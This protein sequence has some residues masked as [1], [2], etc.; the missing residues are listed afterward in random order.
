MRKGLSTRRLWNASMVRSIEIKKAS[1]RDRL[2]VDVDVFMNEPDDFDFSPRAS[3]EGNSLSITNAGADAGGS[4]DLDEDQMNAAERDRM[5]ELR[6]KFSVDGMHGVLTHKT[7]NV[8]DGPNAKKL[9]EP[10]WKTVLPL[11]L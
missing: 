2:I 11:T 5:V 6:V 3:M 8:R 1:V 7:K 10:R 4:I 9:A